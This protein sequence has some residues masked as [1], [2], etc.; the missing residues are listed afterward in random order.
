MLRP[1]ICIANDQ[2]RQDEGFLVRQHPNDV[3]VRASILG[4]L[5]VVVGVTVL[6]RAA[7]IRHV[8][9]KKKVH[10]TSSTG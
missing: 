3:R 5:V 4:T 1:F 9:Y 8:Q 10:Y 6:L 7:K 2:N